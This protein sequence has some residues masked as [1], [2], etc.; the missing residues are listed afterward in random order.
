MKN[1]N[2]L[3]YIEF[4]QEE[5]EMLCS[6]INRFGDGGHP[7]AD[8]DSFDYFTISYLKD[9]FKKK[10]FIASTGKLSELG[11]K[12][13]AE[14]MTKLDKDVTVKHYTSDQI[15]KAFDKLNRLQKMETLFEAL[16]Y[17]SQYNGRTKIT[18]IA[19]AMGYDNTEGEDDTFFKVI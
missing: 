16:D 11:K 19:L 3:R 14:I 10:K 12:T 5:K 15:Q 13:L 4:T 9:I 2:T 1:L 7:V 18:C 17:M 8:T 6:I